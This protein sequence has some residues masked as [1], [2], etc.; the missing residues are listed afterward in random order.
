[1]SLVLC[2]QR[3]TRL[4][5]I[6]YETETCEMGCAELE[7]RLQVKGTGKGNENLLTLLIK[8]FLVLL[9]SS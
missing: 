6:T 1:M 5:F 9:P 2:K 3:H 4:K 7:C 8:H